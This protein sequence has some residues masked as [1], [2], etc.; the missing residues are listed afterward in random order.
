MEK[1]RKQY[2][3]E[4]DDL[5]DCLQQL[6]RMACTAVFESVQSL[7][8]LDEERAQQVIDHDQEIDDLEEQVE[9]QVMRLLALQSPVAGDLRKIATAFKIAIDIERLGDLAKEIAHV[10]IR[11][12]GEPHVKPLIDVPRMANMVMEMLQKAMRSYEER[13]VELAR[14]TAKMDDEIDRLYDL[15]RRELIEMMIEDPSRVN[16]ASNLMFTARYL[17]RMGDHATNICESTVYM[18]KGEREHLN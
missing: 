10:T 3:E 18:V 4:L 14:E 12:A 1:V 16:N 7:K 17:E 11:N 13:D 9:M 15:I 8:E 6:S 5:M 2:T